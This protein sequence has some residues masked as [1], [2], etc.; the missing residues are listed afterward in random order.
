M[1]N[2]CVILVGGLGTRLGEKARTTPNPMREAG[3]T[4][5]LETLLGEARRRGFDDFL[6]L[7]GHRCEAVVAL[8]A[9]RGVERRFACRVALSVAPAPLGAGGALV[10]ALPRL[11]EGFLFLD[12]DAWFDFNW[13]DLV[14]R[15]RRDGAGAALALREI[16][17]PDRYETVE[18]DGSRVV[19]IRPRGQNLAPALIKGGVYYFTR[20][21][22][23][24]SVAASS[25][26]RDIL[27]KLISRGVLRGYRYSGFFIDIGVPESLAAAVELAPGRRRR[28]AVFLDRDGVL[29]ADH[30][31]TRRRPVSCSTDA[32]TRSGSASLS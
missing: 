4:P 21:V 8:L 16:A 10:N 13:L 23:E 12:G 30:G 2:Q 1:A 27:P 31:Y 17:E 3:G 7:A 29:N 6:L 32:R 24:E 9:E 5:F 19:A 11:R 15:A 25:L 28:P 18:L 26:E 22:V 14:V 20:R